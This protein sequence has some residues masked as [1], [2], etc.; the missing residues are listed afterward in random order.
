MVVRGG[1]VLVNLN[2]METCINLHCDKFLR[3]QASPR[4]RICQRDLVTTVCVEG[5]PKGWVIIALFL[6]F[7]VL[8][9]QSKSA[10]SIKVCMPAPI[11]SPSHSIEG[12]VISRLSHLHRERRQWSHMIT[13][14]WSHVNDSSC[15]GM[16]RLTLDLWVKVHVGIVYSTDDPHKFL[17]IL[18]LQK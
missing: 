9:I 1:E 15:P 4:E 7:W 17:S 13:S 6:I 12:S 18:P 2:I 10:K 8:R 3:Q 5:V 14:W 16:W 11:R